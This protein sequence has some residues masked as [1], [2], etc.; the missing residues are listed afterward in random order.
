MEQVNVGI[1]GLGNVGSGTMAI[2]A[3]NGEQ[4]DL[5]L[6]FRLRV[7]AVCSRHTEQKKIPEAL[8][9]VLKSNDWRQLV[10]HPELHI[11]VEL[12]GG[13]QIAAE[14]VNTAIANK[15][16][17]VTANKELMA[18]SGAELWDRAIAA[19]TNLAMEASVA[20]G[21]PIHAVLRAVSYTHLDVYK[22]QT[23][24]EPRSRMNSAAG[25]CTFPR[26]K[27]AVRSP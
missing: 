26:G 25:A 21:I 13:T 18:S 4:I 20:G 27:Q 12:V 1:I 11:I 17:V 7:K 24:P 3:E 10:S 2:L 8:G 19:H 16:S 9:P 23:K 15:K 6:G 5:K 22:R 14:I